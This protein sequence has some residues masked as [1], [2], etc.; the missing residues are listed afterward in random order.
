MK[1]AHNLKD[2]IVKSNDFMFEV[3][4]QNFPNINFISCCIT[5]C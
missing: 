3:R 4:Q 2:V 5:L 1:Y